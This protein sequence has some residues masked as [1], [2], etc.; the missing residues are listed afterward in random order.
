MLD[1]S[2]QSIK[3]LRLKNARRCMICHAPSASS[4]TIVSQAKFCTRTFVD[5]KRSTSVDVAAMG[6]GRNS[7]VLTVRVLKSLLSSFEVVHL[8]YDFLDDSLELAH[9]S[10]ESR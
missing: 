2:N 6:W 5:T 9:L 3:Y 1:V 4:A 7:L 8:V 10:F